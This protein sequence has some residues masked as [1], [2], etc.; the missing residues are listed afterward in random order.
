MIDPNELVVQIL[1]DALPVDVGTEIPADRTVQYVQVS[2]GADTSDEFLLTPRMEL[3]CWGSSDRDAYRLA[4][5]A[6]DALHDA[7]LDHDYLSAVVL[8]TMRRDEWS[9]TGQSRYLVEVDL[10]INTDE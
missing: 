5:Q 9:R 3:L 10:T 8:V 2:I 6:I 4:R 7:S 1:S